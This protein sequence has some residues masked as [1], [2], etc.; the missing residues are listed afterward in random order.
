MQNSGAEDVSDKLTV[1]IVDVTT[2]VFKEVEPSHIGTW[3][4][5][6]G[7]VSTPPMPGA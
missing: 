1:D 2:A 4:L 6:T 7:G 5:D 3:S